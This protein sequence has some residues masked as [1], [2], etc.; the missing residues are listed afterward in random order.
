MYIG[1][2]KSKP[3]EKSVR[4]FAPTEKLRADLQIKDLLLESVLQKCLEIVVVVCAS[5]RY[6]R[7][8]LDEAPQPQQ[9]T[10][11]SAEIEERK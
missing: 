5:K 11:L 2:E 7:D 1:D 4:I 6:A 9:T 10:K 8:N 3:Y